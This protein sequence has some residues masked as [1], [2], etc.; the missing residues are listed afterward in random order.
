[1]DSVRTVKITRKVMSYVSKR[2]GE[3]RTSYSYSVTLPKDFLSEIGVLIKEDNE[4]RLATD[5]L[6]AEVSKSKGKP[7]IILYKP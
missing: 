5:V 1:M 6:I 7:A 4:E 3:Q 2:K